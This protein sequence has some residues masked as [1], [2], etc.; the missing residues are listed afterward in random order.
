MG[1]E[2]RILFEEKDWTREF[3]DLKT[4]NDAFNG[5]IKAE[6]IV[7]VSEQV[8]NVLEFKNMDPES[9]FYYMV[10]RQMNPFL[11]ANFNENQLAYT[12]GSEALDSRFRVPRVPADP[13]KA[14]S[15]NRML[16]QGY[17]YTQESLEAIKEQIADLREKF[18]MPFDELYHKE[19]KLVDAVIKATQALREKESSLPDPMGADRKFDLSELKGEYLGEEF[20][21]E[22]QFVRDQRKRSKI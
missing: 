9:R 16:F 14:P 12:S 3:E 5:T 2:E 11:D 15:V 6:E 13:N 4:Y 7:S 1:K 17:Q 21:K 22:H 8:Q 20:Q 18:D 10:T 19:K